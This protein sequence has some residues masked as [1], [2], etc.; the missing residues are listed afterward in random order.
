MAQIANGKII[1][2]NCGND[3][4]RFCME[5]GSWTRS[6][7]GFLYNENEEADSRIMFHLMRIPS[8]NQVIIRTNDTDVVILTL[9]F[10]KS[11]SPE[12]LVWLDIG[13]ENHRRYLS[14]N[15]LCTHLGPYLCEALVGF[16]AWTGSDYTASFSWKGKVNPFKKLVGDVVAQI[17]FAQLGSTLELS[18]ETA[19]TLEI[20]LCKVHGKATLRNI[21]DVRLDM[22]LAKYGK[23]PRKSKRGLLSVAKGIDAGRLPPCSKVLQMKT[24]RANYV[25][26]MWKKSIDPTFP[27]DMKPEKHGWELNKSGGYEILWFDGAISP[28][29]IEELI[30]ARESRDDEDDLLSEN[31]LL[32]EEDELSEADEESDEEDYY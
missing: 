2:M 7:V 27:E 26:F 30:V 17:A 24:K 12:V 23:R 18:P 8:P 5:N 15:Q 32:S 16:H 6:I 14:A 11:L 22:F 31:D 28:E 19:R 21:N 4:Y 3:C 13:I 1:Y 20:F 10:L 25:S 29:S 9:H